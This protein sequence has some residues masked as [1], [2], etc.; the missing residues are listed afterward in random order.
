MAGQEN[1]QASPQ[2]PTPDERVHCPRFLKMAR[3]PTLKAV[4]FDDLSLKYGAIDFQDC[5]ADYIA[6]S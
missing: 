5:L 3:N 2:P 6:Q 1:H 4:S